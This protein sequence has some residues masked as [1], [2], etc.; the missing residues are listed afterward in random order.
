VFDDREELMRLEVRGLRGD[1]GTYGMDVVLRVPARWGRM[2]YVIVGLAAAAVLL[3][4]FA[5]RAHRVV[6]LTGTLLYMQEGVT[7]A[8]GRLPL[9][10]VGRRRTAVTVDERGR[11]ALGGPGEVLFHLVP[12]RVGGMADVTLPDGKREVRLLVDGIGFVVGRH[13]IRYVQAGGEGSAPPPAAP[14]AVPDLLGPEY[15][16]PHG[17]RDP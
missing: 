2:G 14:P 6:P 4:V 13:A 3:G 17:T 10:P 5:W 12:T 1:R 16:L 8:V 7:D 11:L 15:D 9:T